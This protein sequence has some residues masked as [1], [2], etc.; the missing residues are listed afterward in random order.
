MATVYKGYQAEIDRFVAIKVLPPHPGRTT[1]NSSNASSWRHVRL[2][3]FSIHTSCPCTIMAPKA[4]WCT[5]SWPM[6][7][8]DRW[9]DKIDSGPMTLR[10]VETYLHEIGSALDYAHRQGIV[11]RDIKPD[12]ILINSEGYTL[13]SDFGIVKLLGG[14]SNLT[15][16]GGL[17]G[18]PA[19]MAPEQAQGGEVTPSA[20]IYALGVV[21]YEMIT[22]QQP[23]TADT[24]LHVMLK[25]VT[26]PVPHIS[27][28]M[29]S[30]PVAVENTMLRVLAK[31][32]K[33][34]YATAEDFVNDFSRAIRGQEV[35]QPP[36]SA[37]AGTLV[38]GG[39][40]AQTLQLSSAN[41]MAA[42]GDRPQ[43]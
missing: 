18:T 12:N 39:G 34:R 13:L 31:D 8:A 4:T 26:D 1:R 20:D 27:N 21:A 38:M 22:G 19:Y 23:Y 29:D 35:E 15:A 5:S 17:I 28:V 6:S 32:P 2:P 41:T 7:R 43:R 11:H 30:L 36:E 10:T 25:H 14:D 33:D 24:P 42:S 40:P 3:G 16:T 37:M 9:A